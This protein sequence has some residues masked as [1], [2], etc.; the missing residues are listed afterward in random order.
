M[1][2]DSVFFKALDKS[3]KVNNV[4]CDWLK[5]KGYE[6][7][8]L[9]QETRPIDAPK[10]DRWKYTDSGDIEIIERKRI[11][12]KQRPSLDFKSFNDL[13][14]ENIIVDEE[15]KIDKNH[16]SPIHSY[17]ILNKSMTVAMV[18][19]AETK[20]HWVKQKKFDTVE[21][22]YRCFYLCPKKYCKMVH[23]NR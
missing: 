17:F 5:K 9:P 7:D 11:E 23:L 18:I 13:P 8:L 2:E 1:K 16:D 19:M 12:V 21:G 14:Y 20:K 10:E 3:R 22:E 6:V 4:V 15:Y